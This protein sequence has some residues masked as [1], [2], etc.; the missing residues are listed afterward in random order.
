M[1]AS[2]KR[3]HG[4]VRSW[5]EFAEVLLEPAVPMGADGVPV[6]IPGNDRR[7]F[8]VLQPGPQLPQRSAELGRQRGRRQVASDQ[9]V[10]GVEREHPLDDFLDPFEPELPRRRTT[11][12]AIPRRRLLKSCSG[13][14]A[15][16]QKWMSET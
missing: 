3:S 12:D 16:R 14:R 5:S 7:L 10:I 2:R 9:D 4:Y 13:L 1:S 6:V 15:Y 11:S 8:R